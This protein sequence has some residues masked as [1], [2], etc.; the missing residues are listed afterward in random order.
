[1]RM[2]T[3]SFSLTFNWDPWPWEA[4]DDP[5]LF[6]YYETVNSHVQVQTSG[7][8][9]DNYNWESGVQDNFT[10]TDPDVTSVRFNGVSATFTIDNPNATGSCACGDSFN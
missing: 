5:D 1:M 10:G 3:L 4:D 6:I 2:R 7:V 8:F 9:E